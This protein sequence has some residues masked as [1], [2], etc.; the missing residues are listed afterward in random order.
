MPART[1][2]SAGV[3]NLWS[4]AANWDGGATIPQEGDS[5]IIPSGQTCEYDYNSAYVTGINGITVTGTLKFTRTAGTYKLFMKAATTINGAGV[6][7]IGASALDP[8]PLTA[9]HT[10]TGGTGWKFDGTAGLSLSIF[11]AEPTIKYVKLTANESSGSTVMD[12]D[13]D[14]TGDIW[15]VGDTVRI[16]PVKYTVFGTDKTQD[17][18]IAAG[19]ITSTTITFTAGITLTTMDA[20][21]LL[22]LAERNVKIIGTVSNAALFDAFGTAKITIGGGAFYGNTLAYNVKCTGVVVT[23]GIWLQGNF[24]LGS[25]NISIANFVF[26][27]SNG[28]WTCNTAIITNTLFAGVTTVFNAV[29]GG[30]IN[31]CKF[32][33][34]S[35]ISIIFGSISNSVGEGMSNFL[36]GSYSATVI[37]CTVSKSYE[38]IYRSQA[39]II[40]SQILSGQALSIYS[41]R[42]INTLM[43]GTENAAYMYFSE[44]VYTESID[45][46]QVA[47]AYK[48]WTTGGV[49]TKQAVTKP[50]GYASAMQTVLASASYKGYWQKEITIGAGASVNIEMNLRKDAS[51]TY[52]PRV[53]VFNKATIDPF[54]GGAGL[55]TFT[56]TNSVDTWENDLY[57]YTNSG[58]EDV[59]LVIRC[60]GMN[61]TGNMYSALDIEQINVDLTSAI[62]KIDVVDALV[63][64]IKAKTDQL[65]FTVANQVDANALTGGG[66]ASAA[67]VADAVWNE[68]IAD[69]TTA[70]T[71][72]GKNQKVVPSETIND[73]KVDVSGLATSVSL[74]TV[75]SVVDAI[76]LKTDN[77][78]ADPASEA[79]VNTRLAT[80][81]YTA[82]PSVSAIVT[83]VW[84]ATTRTLS[85]FGTLIADIWGYATRTLSAFGFTVSATPDANVALIK[86]KTDNLPASPAAVGSAMTLT[87]G[88]RTAIANE[89][90]SQIINEADAERVL[91][92][93]TDKIASVNPSLDDLTLAGIASAVRT[94]LGT[95]LARIDAAISSRLSSV[96]YTSPANA[97]VAAIKAKTDNLP[98]DP[99]DQSILAALIGALPAAPS[100]MDIVNALKSSVFD[101][102]LTFEDSIKLYNAILFGKLDGGGSGTLRFRN[103]SD[104]KDRVTAAVD[105]SNGDRDNITLDLT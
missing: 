3:N 63:D 61:A 48:A 7:D 69:H 4:N 65:A 95:E 15:A 35:S 31:N 89:V 93:I 8:I 36:N 17:R 54:A 74:A 25:S 98:N 103:P 66:G 39:D 97:D 24:S 92:A 6:C 86:A 20:G 18:V 62:A 40:N 13:T 38:A 28:I 26:C 101:G 33:C 50:T 84:G 105:L 55:Y 9:K 10:I 59:T 60:Q 30:V 22:V 100:E 72:G 52:L 37:N 56:M 51:V 16:V 90:E 82:P 46:D 73:Y 41:G 88:E 43:T 87:A 5:V 32:Y 64:A 2:T 42:L 21:S 14:V 19:G 11:A 76:K 102:V 68:A 1:F 104:T 85:S 49:T 27:G 58:S 44:L 78:P 47:G 34:T 71:F 94:E 91:T 96:G 57:T 81:G 23:G 79:T 99:A 53:I 67:D 77:L 83:G 29:Y 75:D 12:I 45:H 70:T 80:S